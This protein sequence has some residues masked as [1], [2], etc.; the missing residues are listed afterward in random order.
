ME[1]KNRFGQPVGKLKDLKVY[2]LVSGGTPVWAQKLLFF[3]FPPFWLRGIFL[4]YGAK[5]MGAIYSGDVKTFDNKKI[6][7]KCEKEGYR[8]GKKI[9]KN[10]R[11]GLLERIFWRPPQIN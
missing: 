8:F 11:H 7:K 1:N 2:F 6:L 4:Y 10:K 5:C 3:A 9:L